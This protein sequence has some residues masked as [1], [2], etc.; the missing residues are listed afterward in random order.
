MKRRD[1]ISVAVAA[2][3]FMA[4]LTLFTIDGGIAQ[5]TGLGTRDHPIYWLLP[6]STAGAAVEAVGK[7]IAKDLFEIT[8]LHV[9]L[10]VQANYDSLIKTLAASEG[11]TFGVLTADQYIRIY[12][13]TGGN[14][15]P[16]LG[17]VR[18]GYPWYYSSI[19]ARRDSGIKTLED[20]NGKVWIYND[21]GST[22]GYVLPHDVFVTNG[23]QVGG[24]VE[25]GGHTNSMV[26]LIEGQGDFCTGYGSPPA[27]PAGW[28]GPKWNWGNNPEKWIWDPAKND[29]YDE[30]SRGTC[31]DLRRAV[32]Y[33][34]NLDTVLREIGVV[35]NIGPM[36]NDCLCFGPDFPKEIADKIVEAVKTHIATEEGQA[37]WSD[38]NFYEWTEVAP[39][40]DS[41]YDGY[42]ALLGLA[43]PSDRSAAGYYLSSDLLLDDLKVVTVDP[44]TDK[45]GNRI[46]DIL[47]ER[48]ANDTYARPSADDNRAD[49]FI[50][51]EREPTEG[52]KKA[53]EDCGGEVLDDWEILYVLQAALP[54]SHIPNYVDAH[55]RVVIVEENTPTH[56]HL[57]FS[58]KQ[59]RVRQVWS[60]YKGN[61]DH[62]VAILD[63]GID[64]LH[65]D[66]PVLKD[67]KNTLDKGE[68][69][70]GETTACDAD[71]H[72]THV[73]SIA[74]GRGTMAR[75]SGFSATFTGYF[76][77]PEGTAFY[78]YF[79]VRIT[80]GTGTGTATARLHWGAETDGDQ[81]WIE[82]R[83][84]A[85]AV[86]G[87][88]YKGTVEPLAAKTGAIAAPVQASAYRV[89]FGTEAGDAKKTWGTPYFGQVDVPYDAW[90]TESLLSGVAPACGLVGVKVFRNDGSGDTADLSQGLRWIIANAKKHK[91]VVANYS[92]GGDS[93]N[94]ALNKL[95]GQL[96]SSGVAFVCAAGND[97]AAAKNIASPG[98][99]ADAIT[100]G[101]ISDLDKLT[102]YS[103]VGGVHSKPDVL[104]PG[105]STATHNEIAAADSNDSD[106]CV[107]SRRISVHFPDQYSDDYRMMHGTSMAAP[108]VSGLVALIAQAKG[109]WTWGK[110]DDPMYAKMIILMT[111]TE[112]Q[113]SEAAA[114]TPP[115][116]RGG[117]DSREGFGRINADAAIEAVTKKTTL[118]SAEKATFGPNP[119]DKKCWA[120]KIKLTAGKKYTFKLDVPKE[121]DYDLYLYSSTPT[122]DGDPVIVEKSV[123]GKGNDELIKDF[124]PGKTADYYIVV[125]WVEG[126]GEFSLTK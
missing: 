123:L 50:A 5:A 59:I 4:I 115:L 38:P 114:Y 24:V 20:L 34:Y 112:V 53:I 101:A 41:W 95:V 33:T 3:A 1:F 72:G 71:G 23:I 110:K 100:V 68:P 19:Y 78:N 55:S 84:S 76:P 30:D 57:E 91:I 99:A 108:H 15:T 74:C 105:G 16:R 31:T 64:D 124:Q 69:G 120:R 87:F 42:R 32:R 122:E 58:T 96:V 65:R 126:K 6:T 37:L 46:A 43:I 66:L 116:N 70:F 22:S 48:I 35:A 82:I 109:S 62:T 106:A 81:Y 56:T 63:T 119:D 117:K 40:D 75:T 118:A 45:N 67:W 90:D 27:P 21:P 26:G 36:P 92:G 107:N 86:R 8:G 29:L 17:S 39:I 44:S 47:E 102:D 94:N 54:A 98:V 60:S 88:A 73:A 97:Q 93:V 7:A 25:T 49:V 111:S 28:T 79:P 13:R 104:A 12:E 18:Y 85:N 51:F 113:K 14:V 103:S 89:L 125:K 77:S 9:V 10:R 80:A 121:A 52:D 83:D 61:P 11:D 2:M